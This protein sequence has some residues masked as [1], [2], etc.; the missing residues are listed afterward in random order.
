MVLFDQLSLH[1]GAGLGHLVPNWLTLGIQDAFL[2]PMQSKFSGIWIWTGQHL[3]SQNR[4]VSATQD[5]A[6]AYIVLEGS[7][8]EQGDA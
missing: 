8:P 5:T 6:P 3:P 4:M 1:L 7:L 2:V